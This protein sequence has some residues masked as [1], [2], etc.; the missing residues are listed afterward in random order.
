MQ[1]SVETEPHANNARYVPH[2][3]QVSCYYFCSLQF[4]TFVHLDTF[5][6]KFATDIQSLGTLTNSEI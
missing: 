6:T 1:V 2:L 3:K 4:Y 5:K